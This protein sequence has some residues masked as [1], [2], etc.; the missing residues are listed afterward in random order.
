MLTRHQRIVH[1][2]DGRLLIEAAALPT[3][4]QDLQTAAIEREPRILDRLIDVFGDPGRPGLEW[5]VVELDHR[6]LTRFRPAAERH[7][8]DHVGVLEPPGLVAKHRDRKI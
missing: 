2:L 7:E 6:R 8:L 3:R 5:S 4:P 1:S